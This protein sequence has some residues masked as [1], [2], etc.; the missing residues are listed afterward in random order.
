MT[1]YEDNVFIVKAT[2][3]NNCNDTLYIRRNSSGAAGLSIIPF[4]KDHHS[5]TINDNAVLMVSNFE[6][7]RSELG[8]DPFSF[9]VAFTKRQ[10]RLYE[11]YK[12][13]HYTDI[14]SS[15]DTISIDSK[16]YYILPPKKK[17]KFVRLYKGSYHDVDA[18][19]NI[20]KTGKK[21]LTQLILKFVYRTNT[22]D[23]LLVKVFSSK[24]CNKFC[25]D[26]YG[27]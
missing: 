13:K 10:N 16:V 26:I 20:C 4:Q 5:S 19:N 22:Y 27:Y 12:Q 21:D 17:V 24:D 8:T 1:K 25:R 3:I 9:F 11:E 6:Q 7:Y 23:T 2:L 18:L 15:L 14:N